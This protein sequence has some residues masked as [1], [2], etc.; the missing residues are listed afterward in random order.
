MKSQGLQRF[1]ILCTLFVQQKMAS[2]Y[3]NP[4]FSS[5]FRTRTVILE[6]TVFP[7]NRSLNVDRNQLKF[8]VWFFRVAS[9]SRHWT[10]D[11]K[12][13]LL[14]YFAW[15]CSH[16][17]QPTNKTASHYHYEAIKT[18]APRPYHSI[19]A[20]HARPGSWHDL[21]TGL[22]TSPSCLSFGG[23]VIFPNWSFWGGGG[24]GGRGVSPT[25]LPG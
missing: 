4:C 22:S 23:R 10:W 13:R 3:C 5:W 6:E 7:C 20:D 21:L 12:Q 8:I 25:Y 19:L 16:L 1:L 18:T 15:H 9:V 11:W 24:G 14:K 2:Q 17:L